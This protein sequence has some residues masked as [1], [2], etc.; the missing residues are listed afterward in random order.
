MDPAMFLLVVGAVVIANHKDASVE[1]VVANG[2]KDPLGEMAAVEREDVN[3]LS[4]GVGV[5]AMLQKE[6][7]QA[8]FQGCEEGG[9]LRV[10]F[11]IQNIL[12]DPKGEELFGGE[13]ESRQFKGL[14]IGVVGVSAPAAIVD[15]RRVE[16]IAKV[17]DITLDGGFRQFKVVGELSDGHNVSPLEQGVQFVESL[18]SVHGVGLGARGRGAMAHARYL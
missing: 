1:E 4:D 14:C 8:L 9:E 12:H 2:G 13:P 5:V 18:K 3:G 17:M 7:F 10:G 16:K 11:R 6:G 15:Q